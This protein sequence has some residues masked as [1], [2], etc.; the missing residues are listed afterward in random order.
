MYK[1]LALGH[2]GLG[3]LRDLLRLS[4]NRSAYT[5]LRNACSHPCLRVAPPL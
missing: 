1:Q 3:G 4:A 5:I 2:H